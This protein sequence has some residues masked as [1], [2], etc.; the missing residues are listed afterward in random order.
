MCERVIERETESTLTFQTNVT[1]YLQARSGGSDIHR[2]GTYVSTAAA[3]SSAFCIAT[4][5]MEK[6]GM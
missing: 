6:V 5:S 4:D 3:K 1:Q 2:L